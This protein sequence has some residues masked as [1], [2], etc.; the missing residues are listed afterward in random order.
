V[1]DTIRA[2]FAA[3]IATSAVLWFVWLGGIVAA[4][5]TA[6]RHLF[7]SLALG[8]GLGILLCSSVAVNA[9]GIASIALSIDLP[10]WAWTAEVIALVLAETAGT[11]I[12]LSAAI[13]EA[14]F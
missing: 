11:A 4:A 7:V 14:P 9:L 6:R 5:I 1:D 2:I 13:A 12:A 10:E 3:W 8:T